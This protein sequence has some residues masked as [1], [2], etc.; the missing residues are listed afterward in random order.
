MDL[1]S[2]GFRALQAV[3]LLLLAVV[4]VNSQVRCCHQF[5]CERLVLS[6]V[7]GFMQICVTIMTKG[8]CS[9]ASVLLRKLQDAMSQLAYMHSTD[10]KQHTRLGMPLLSSISPLSCTLS[11]TVQSQ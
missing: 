11:S 6:P 5:S 7:Q 3:L 4:H 10:H 2:R 8:R 9:I 1:H